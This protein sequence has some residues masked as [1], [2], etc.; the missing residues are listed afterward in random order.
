MLEILARFWNAESTLV[1][2]SCTRFVGDKVD[3]P[4]ITSISL[5]FNHATI[6]FRVDPD[7]DTIVTSIGKIASQPNEEIIAMDRMLPWS[8]CLNRHLSWGWELTNQQGYFDGVRLE[9]KSK[10]EVSTVVEMVA[11][12]SGLRVFEATDI[13]DPNSDSKTKT[14]TVDN[15]NSMRDR[16]PDMPALLAAIREAPGMYIGLP[17]ITGLHHLLHGI[18]FA[19]SFYEVPASQQLGGFDFHGFEEWVNTTYNLKRQSHNSFS[20]ADHLTWSSGMVFEEDYQNLLH[21]NSAQS[22]AAFDLWFRWYDEFSRIGNKE[23]A[24]T[25]Q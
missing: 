11:V 5:E 6:V 12:A 1:S 20:L 4:F 25:N 18:S 16:Y 8:N 9:F 23:P 17:T 21:A 13:R 7:T 22:A 19:E 2:V 10:E 15:P 24:R 3:H 14:Y